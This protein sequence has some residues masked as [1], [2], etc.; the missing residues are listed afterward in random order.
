MEIDVIAYRKQRGLTQQKLAEL[1]GVTVR[2]IQ[3]W[4]NSNKVP[5][6]MV[7]LMNSIDTVSLTSTKSN[8]QQESP[9][10]I[11]RLLAIIERQQD[12][13]CS[14]LEKIA[15]MLVFTRKHDEQIDRLITILEK[16]L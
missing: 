13:M 2:T 4:E 16:R 6:A 11:E 5:D 7:K 14:Q 9:E 15:E 1:L 3:Y 8:T 10:Q 12:I